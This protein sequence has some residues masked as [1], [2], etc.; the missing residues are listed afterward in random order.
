[1]QRLT[2]G[3]AGEKGL[4]VFAR[5]LITPGEII[6]TCPVLAVE[7]DDIVDG[8]LLDQ[9][10]YEWGPS[11]CAVALGYG[12]LYNHSFDPNAVFQTDLPHGTITITARRRIQ[13]GEEVTINYN[14]DPACADPV[15]FEC[16]EAAPASRAYGDADDDDS[17]A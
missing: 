1:M 8:A 17:A 12:S 6:E 4:G 2:I 13:P 7:N 16:I 10:V 11:R 3:A 15:D 9:Y 14:G 5:E